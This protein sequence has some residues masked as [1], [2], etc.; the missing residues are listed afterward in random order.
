MTDYVELRR[1]P[2]GCQNSVTPANRHVAREDTGFDTPHDLPS[3]QH[4]HD[5][6]IQAGSSALLFTRANG[7]EPQ[8]QRSPFRFL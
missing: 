7:D 2:V 8:L 4:T 1:H 3:V 6:S 5:P